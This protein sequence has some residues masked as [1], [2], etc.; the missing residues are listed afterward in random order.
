MNYIT[1]YF[2]E[3]PHPH[4]CKD[5]QPNDS[6]IS[7]NMFA[8]VFLMPRAGALKSIP[9]D[10][11]ASGKISLTTVLIL[12]SLFGVSHVAMLIRLKEL[13]LISNSI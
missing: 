7:A 6:E 2:D 8:R 4:F 5:H 11:L 10:E 12:E 13:K 3:N 9:D 1:L